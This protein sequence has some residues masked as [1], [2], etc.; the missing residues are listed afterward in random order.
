MFNG[1]YPQNFIIKYRYVLDAKWTTVNVTNQQQSVNKSCTKFV[2]GLSKDKE[3]I[4]YMYAE[5]VIGKS[6]YTDLVRA[7]TYSDSKYL[8]SSSNLYINIP[9]HTTMGHG[10]LMIYNTKCAMLF[11]RLVNM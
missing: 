9:R 4:T 7:K 10:Y 2:Q 6:G 1:G 5:N 11:A 3:Y 8:L